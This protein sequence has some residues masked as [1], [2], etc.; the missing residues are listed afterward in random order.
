MSTRPIPTKGRFPYFDHR[1]CA[2]VFAGSVGA[3]APPLRR[4]RKPV[5][6]AAF[7][8]LYRKGHSCCEIAWAFGVTVNCV[9]RA[10]HRMHVKLRGRGSRGIG[11]VQ[12]T[13]SA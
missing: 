9:Q 1:T 6:D 4:S 11:P 2:E 10:L 12:M 8:R 5:R 3:F 7:V 13:E